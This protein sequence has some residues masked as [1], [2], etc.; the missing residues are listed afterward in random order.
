MS[1]QSTAPF[2]PPQADE[3]HDSDESIC[4]YAI[5]PA[6]LLA[7]MPLA[8]IDA[9]RPVYILESSHLQ[10]VVSRVRAARFDLPA[11]EAGLSNPDWLE[12]HVRA[13]QQVLDSLVATGQPVLPMRFCTLYRDEAAVQ[14]ILSAHAEPMRVELDRLGGKQEWGVKLFVHGKML[15]A[16]I[17]S[18]DGSSGDWAQ[19]DEIMALQTKIDGLSAGA[20]FLFKKKLAAA[21]DE[22]AEELAFSIALRSHERLSS[23]AAEAVTNAL[24]KGKDLPQMFLN[25]AYLVVEAE[26]AAFFESLGQMDQLYSAAGVRYEVS[27]PWPAY[28]FIQLQL[29]D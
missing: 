1:E 8:G 27:G 6:G 4:L 10:A 24:Y 13:H 3:Q 20:A 7:L 14:S 9:D 19:N 17:L 21:V 22:R 12:T 25:A 18:P 23:C 29:D 16:T 26:S 15:R 28:N 11:L 5:L 2:I